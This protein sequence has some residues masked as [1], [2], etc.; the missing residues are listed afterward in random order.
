MKKTL[1]NKSFLLF[2]SSLFKNILRFMGLCSACFVFEACYGTPMGEY[3]SDMNID[4]KGSVKSEQN[5][6][7]I[8]GIKVSLSVNGK[9]IETNTNSNGE[10]SFNNNLYNESSTFVLTAEDI[11]GDINGN[12]SPTDENLIITENDLIKWQNPILRC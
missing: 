8:E 9:I 10:Y 3:E 2:K 5:D 6:E 11:D 12:Y 1:S 7:N 4:I